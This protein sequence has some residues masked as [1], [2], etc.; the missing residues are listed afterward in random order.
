[1][2]RKINFLVFFIG[3]S[4][5]S[6]CSQLPPDDNHVEEPVF[7]VKMENDKAVFL[8]NG[9]P[10]FINGVG[11]SY[12]LD[13]AAGYGVN[14]FRTWGIDNV[15]QDLTNAL[16]NNMYVMVGI[17]LSQNLAD[18]QKDSYK[19]A[20]RAQVQYLLDNYK[21]HPNLMIWA[22]GNEVRWNA[23]SAPFLNEL[24]TMIREQDKNHP[25]CAVVLHS[26]DDVNAIAD[27]APSVE[28]I[29]FNT[30]GGI[31]VMKN[32]FMNS[33]WKGP[34]I[35]SEWGPNGHWEVQKTAWGAPIEPTS[36][37]KKQQ[38]YNNYTQ[39]IQ[40]N[41][42]CIGSFVFYW[43]QKQER[44][45]TWYSMF[46][47]QNVANLPVNGE[48]CPTVEVMEELWTKREAVE[49]APVVD[50]ITMNGQAVMQTE[51]F[52]AGSTVSAI[53][54]ASDPRGYA[55]VYYWEI[56]KEA[57]V[58]GEGGSY[59]PRPER[60]GEIITG[61]S[62]V[63]NIVLPSQAGNYRLFVYVL[64]GRGMAGTSNIPFQITPR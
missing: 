9:E 25:V 45:P 21:E 46:L 57:T 33:R 1:M 37:A 20:I 36:A 18:Y 24:A 27:Y 40:N 47:E 58:L 11:G 49:K 44:T 59:E 4:I 32:L 3:L 5:L 41:D 48:A 63:Q 42:R 19:N 61:S 62:N 12:Q 43:A 8:H 16:Q 15:G 14:A 39:Y 7:S 6:A 56:L 60:I 26:Q 29:G 2:L 17:W 52:A 10:F 35:V 23:A 53:V 30:Y 51:G 50:G 64:N 55:L 54:N 34:Y 38:Y 31:S 28:I 13:K 22:L